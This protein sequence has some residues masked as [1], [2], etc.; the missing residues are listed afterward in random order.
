MEIPKS[1]CD[2][3]TASQDMDD[4]LAKL[5]HLEETNA[6]QTAAL[7]HVNERLRELDPLYGPAEIDRLEDRA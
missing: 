7:D 4:V 6:E 3:P 2:V 1:T 5:D